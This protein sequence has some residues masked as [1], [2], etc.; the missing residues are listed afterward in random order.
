MDA[1]KVIVELLVK[2][3]QFDAAAKQSAATYEG[4]MNRIVSAGAKAETAAARSSDARS[5]ALRKESAQISA[6]SR[7]IGTQLNDIG[8]LLN[9]PNSPFVVP[10]KQA[11]AVNKAMLLVSAGASALGGVIGGV[12]VSAVLAYV[13]SLA[14]MILKQKSAS[15]EINDLVEKLQ[16]QARKTEIAR[17]AKAAYEQTLEGVT[18]AIRANRDA[19]RELK[20]EEEGAAEREANAAALNLL[21]IE[22]IKTETQALVDQALAIL[23]VQRARAS[24][25]GQGAELAALNLPERQRNLDDLEARLKGVNVQLGLAQ[26]NFR[27]VFKLAVAER[28]EAVADPLKE[29]E[30]RYKGLI[31]E[32]TRLATAEEARNGTLGRQ[33]KL[34]KE[35][36]KAE[37]DAYRASQ[38]NTS[39]QSGRQINEAQARA[40]VASIGGTVTSGTRTAKHN[41]DVGG[42]PNSFHVKG[43]AVDIAKT[44]GMT[45]GKIIK[46]FEKEGVS[47][48]E[49]LDEGD[50]FHIAWSKRGG[51]GPSEETLAKRAMAA[52]LEAERREQAFTNEKGSLDGQVIDARRALVV[53]AEE[54]AKLE[55]EAIEQSRVQYNEKLASLVEQNR[56][57]GGTKGLLQAEADEL[58]KANDERA[59][60]RAELVKRREE[61]RKFRLQEAE[62]QRKIENQAADIATERE[63]QESRSGIADT[64]KQRHDLEKRLI[65]LAFNEERLALQATIAGAERLRIEM[66]RLQTLR[67]LSDE[68]KAAL[69]R[70]QDQAKVA[71]DRLGT[72]PEREA[73]A[74]K[75][76][77]KA[78][79]TPLQQFFQEIPDTAGEINEAL[80]S[81]AAG[82]LT[83]LTD[84]LAQAIV[85]FESLGE[86]GR[87][88]ALQ[89][90]EALV[91]L[92][93]QQ[94]VVNTLGKA[95]G[96]DQKTGADAAKEAAQQLTTKLAGLVAQQIALNTISQ[97]LGAAATAA[98]AAQAAALAAAWAPAAAAASLAT[99]GANAGPASAALAT[100]HALS[101]GL[102]MPKG[103]LEG[104]YTGSGDPRKAAG[105]VHG[106]EYV[107]DAPATRRIGVGNLEALRSGKITPSNAV[108]VAPGRGGGGFSKDDISALRGIVGEAIAAQPDIKLYPTLDPVQVLQAAFSDPRGKRF[109]MEFFGDNRGSINGTLQS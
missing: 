71:Q 11:P 8:H 49:K 65:T 15:E 52:A 27:D 95:F 82:G 51:N 56:I 16:E 46:A 38:R 3:G 81:I 66:E 100:V 99:L 90:A 97:S 41:E 96:Q 58:Q 57:S 78:N 73:N 88:A 10:Q 63:L 76:N 19:I 9:G 59:K 48:I 98:T 50:H 92:A 75:G 7:I 43:Q 106:Q 107:F 62:A 79:A 85:H 60:L 37:E 80:E 93:L 28:A 12:L 70:A 105:I 32:T 39:E 24:G 83:S 30:V 42:V 54:I 103:F 5:A 14:E 33:I 55:L 25:P 20:R 6:T 109:V 91:R 2:N 94:V 29:I 21:R 61:Q 35:K 17:Q 1:E 64:A 31:K 108:A 74:Q 18:V 53:A 40:I 69:Q 26:S 36:Q 34:L 86:V 47:L 101:A 13:A 45:L 22:R 68:E 4:S 87:A 89:I 104:G 23:E 84:G 72:L 77:D 67:D 44:A 102:A